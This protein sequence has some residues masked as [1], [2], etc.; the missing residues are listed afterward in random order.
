MRNKYCPKKIPEEKKIR[1]DIPF[2]YS[3]NHY[4]PLKWFQY[5]RKFDDNMEYARQNNGAPKDQLM[6]SYCQTPESET[7]KHKRCS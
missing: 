1:A 4:A 3:W 7:T 5:L 6:C 2:L